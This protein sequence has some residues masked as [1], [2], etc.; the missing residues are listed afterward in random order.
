MGNRNILDD[1]GLKE[2]KETV[3]ASRGTHKEVMTIKNRLVLLWQE[4]LS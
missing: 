3:S 1:I 4:S 2:S